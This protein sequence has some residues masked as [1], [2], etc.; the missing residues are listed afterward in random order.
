MRTVQLKLPD[1]WPATP[2]G[3]VPCVKDVFERV[4]VRSW[5]T[6]VSTGGVRFETYQLVWLVAT[7]IAYG[8]HLDISLLPYDMASLLP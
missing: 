6:S 7:Q 3:V 2:Q 8:S 1:E 5:I 4:M